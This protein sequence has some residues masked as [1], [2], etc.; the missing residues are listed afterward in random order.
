MKKASTLIIIIAIILTG[1]SQMDN[2]D[3][4][5]K[6][7]PQNAE[8]NSFSANYYATYSSSGGDRILN[9]SYEVDN[10]EIVSCQ[11][12]YTTATI[13]EETTTDCELD[14]LLTQE[15]NVPLE[16]V[17][18]YYLGNESYYNNQGRSYYNWSIIN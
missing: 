5:E 2:N 12:T 7:I 16:L 11:G 10:N 4:N 9:I 17:T 15:Y 1:C 3:E 13:D 8:I 6:I 18:Q 14:R